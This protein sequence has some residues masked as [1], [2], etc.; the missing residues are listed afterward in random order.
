MVGLEPGRA[1]DEHLSD[2][3]VGP[4]NVGGPGSGDP[5][6]D[7]REICLRQLA[8]RARSRAELAATLRRRGVL[9]EHAE[10][11]LDRLT[12]VGLIDDAAFA[13]A[14]V[15]SARA[16]RGL[17]RRALSV[18][19]R[20]RGVDPD[21]VESVMAAVEPDDEEEV[22]RELVRRRLRSMDQL[23]DLARVRRL[24]AMLTRKGYA[25]DVAMRVVGEQVGRSPDEGAE[26]VS[27]NGVAEDDSTA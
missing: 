15:S 5:V 10:T 12:E 17:G 8:T 26:M 4:P 3:V 24:V 13:A 7:A 23:S 27:A 1:G 18:E 21:T 14:F 16:N 11:V 19:L 2:A 22:A 6:S 20:R 25:L 9:D